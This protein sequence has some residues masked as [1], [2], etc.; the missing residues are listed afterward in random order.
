MKQM[1]EMNIN[2][3]DSDFAEIET[4]IIT[5]ENGVETE[6]VIIDTI[7]MGGATFILVVDA[8]QAEDDEAEVFVLKQVGEDDDN[9]T[10]EEPTDEEFEVVS[11]MF[12]EQSDEY[13]I[14]V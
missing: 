6:H 7:E 1:D 4:L 5:D 9:Y 12:N 2:D 14:E 13:D 10:Y 3:F 8:N 11:R